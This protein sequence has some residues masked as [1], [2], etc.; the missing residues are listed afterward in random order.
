M[1]FGTCYEFTYMYCGTIGGGAVEVFV[2]R[3]K[4]CMRRL[5]YSAFWL[6][7]GGAIFFSTVLMAINT[8]CI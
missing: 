7:V 1:E 4:I 2:G 8:V 5:L 6:W 3:S